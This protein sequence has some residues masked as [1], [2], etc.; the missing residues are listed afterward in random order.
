[1][2]NLPTRLG[3]DVRPHLFSCGSHNLVLPV[4]RLIALARY[5][6]L[7]YLEASKKFLEEAGP[8]VR[9]YAVQSDIFPY[10]KIQLGF[11]FSKL[12]LRTD[13]PGAGVH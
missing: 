5:K 8:A 13:L 10:F 2:H 3:L 7:L 1:M 12:K 9:V 11:I 6:F 4:H